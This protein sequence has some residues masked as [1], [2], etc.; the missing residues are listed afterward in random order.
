MHRALVVVGFLLAFGSGCIVDGYCNDTVAGAPACEPSS[1]ETH[2]RGED[3]APTAELL[4]VEL[5]DQRTTTWIATGGSA[6][7]RIQTTYLAAVTVSFRGRPLDAAPSGAWL[8]EHVTVGDFLEVHGTKATNTPFGARLLLSTAPVG[9]VTLAPT[10]AYSR[11]RDGAPVFLAFAG[12]TPV[13]SIQLR[14][15][16]GDRLVDQSM[17]LDAAQTSSDVEQVAWDRL[18]LPTTP[19]AHR[20]R[21]T[22]DSFG[23]RDFDLSVVD[24]LDRLASSR[25]AST[26]C[27]HAMAA[28]QEV[29]A[30]WT[31][32]VDEVLV[33]TNGRNCVVAP[34]LATVVARAGGLELT[35]TPA[36]P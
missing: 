13:S 27:F 25:H 1:E 33:E 34:A 10:S 32:I 5:S 11:Q 15:V 8:V 20:L 24:Q 2:P 31:V 30:T 16:G 18:R 9:E 12:A 3:A 17:L 28:E 21:L 26:L 6:E 29:F 19:G 22:A 23:A 35:V 36:A 14:S 4:P 7:R